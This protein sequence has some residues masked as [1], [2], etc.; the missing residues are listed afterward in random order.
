MHI[1]YRSEQKFVFPIKIFCQCVQISSIVDYFMVAI[2]LT[3]F[4]LQSL[5][6]RIKCFIKYIATV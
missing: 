2:N 6:Y 3:Q 5:I 1:E 4:L